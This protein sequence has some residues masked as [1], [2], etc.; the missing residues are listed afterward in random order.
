MNFSFNLKKKGNQC[1]TKSLFKFLSLENNSKLYKQKHIL[2]CLKGTYKTFSAK[3]DQTGLDA[4]LVYK[5]LSTNFMLLI[6]ILT[7]KD[8]YGIYR[9]CLSAVLCMNTIPFLDTACSLPKGWE[10]TCEHRTQDRS[11]SDTLV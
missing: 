2:R 9:H 6:R 5:V 7:S 4:N 8:H 3:I 10:T 1:Y 11:H